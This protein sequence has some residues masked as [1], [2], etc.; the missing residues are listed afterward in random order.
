MPK[1]LKV[2]NKTGRILYDATWLE[3]V[4]YQEEDY[5][6]NPEDDDHVSI[7]T[8]YSTKTEEQD[9]QDDE[10]DEEASYRANP[11][12]FEHIE[13][14]ENIEEEEEPIEEEETIEEAQDPSEEVEDPLTCFSTPELRERH[15]KK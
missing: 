4:D 7:E 2:S 6:I 12:T 5:E 15:S 3:G 10:I 13:E 9:E 14:V 8:E 1:G 11:S